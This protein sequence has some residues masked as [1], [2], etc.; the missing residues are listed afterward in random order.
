MGHGC[1]GSQCRSKARDQP[2]WSQLDWLCWMMDELASSP[3]VPETTRYI[4]LSTGFFEEGAAG[5]MLATVTTRRVYD[6]LGNLCEVRPRHHQHRPAS[7]RSFP[8]PE[9]RLPAQAP[10]QPWD[11]LSPV[12]QVRR[13]ITPASHEEYDHALAAS[14][15]LCRPFAAAMGDVRTARECLE[16]YKADRAAGVAGLDAAT[17]GRLAAAMEARL[18]AA[19]ASGRRQVLLENGSLL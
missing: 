3:L 12:P 1:F 8:L 7:A 11:P 17:A 10:R 18:A 19:A 6:C 14:P 15:D 9:R 16:G 13:L 5:A 4:R 2:I